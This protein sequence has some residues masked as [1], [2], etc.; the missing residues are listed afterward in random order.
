[1]LSLL[2]KTFC[3]TLNWSHCK[4]TFSTATHLLYLSHYKHHIRILR[5]D[6]LP[7]NV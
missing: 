5:T 1:M 7:F 2:Q 4:I 6:K 3:E